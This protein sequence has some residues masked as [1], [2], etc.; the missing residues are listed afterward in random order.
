MEIQRKDLWLVLNFAI[1]QRTG[2]KTAQSCFKNGNYI[3][4]NAAISRMAEIMIPPNPPHTAP[5]ALNPSNPCE[6]HA[7]IRPRKR[8]ATQTASMNKKRSALI[9]QS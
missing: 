4:M 2:K 3:P 1:V 7:Y 9:S 6:C 5:K 8:E